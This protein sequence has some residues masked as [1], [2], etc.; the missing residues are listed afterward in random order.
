MMMREYNDACDS[1]DRQSAL[2]NLITLVGEL[3][4]RLSPW[5]VR[6]EKAVSFGVGVVGIAS[7]A[8]STVIAIAKAL[9]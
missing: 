9:T 5:Y 4:R 7:G 2:M 6:H 1:G 3:K 8:T